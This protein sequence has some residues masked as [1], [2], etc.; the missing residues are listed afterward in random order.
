MNLEK[1]RLCIKTIK[2]CTQAV[3]SDNVPAKSYYVN[4]IY[5][6]CETLNELIEKL[7]DEEL[8]E[9]VSVLK[10]ERICDE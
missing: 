4:S 10:H 7:E 8:I 9:V 3:A 6:C 5:R 2:D 1:Y